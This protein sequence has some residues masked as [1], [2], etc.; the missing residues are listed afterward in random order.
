MKQIQ[1][2]INV[3]EK[4]KK[5]SSEEENKLPIIKFTEEF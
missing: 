5:K 3:K 2:L 4:G 1:N